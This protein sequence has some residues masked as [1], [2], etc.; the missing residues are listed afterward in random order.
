[1]PTPNGLAT[2]DESVRADT[3]PEA[4]TT[5]V[6]E[7]PRSGRRVLPPLLDGPPTANPEVRFHS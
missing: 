4:L 1:M 5:L 6:H 7:P 3:S 2:T